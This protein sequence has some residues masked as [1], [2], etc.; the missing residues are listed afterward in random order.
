MNDFQ[1]IA[2]FDWSIAD[3]VLRNDIKRGRDPSVYGKDWSKEQAFICEEAARGG[4]GRFGAGT[5]RISDG[6]ILFLQHMLLKTKPVAE[7]GSRIAI[8]INGSPLFSG[9]TGSGESEVR[10]WILEKDWL[11]TGKID[12]RGSTQV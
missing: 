7:G 12:V 11:E 1:K 8:V 4:A 9:D 3:E 2:N 6:Q 5:P 10:R